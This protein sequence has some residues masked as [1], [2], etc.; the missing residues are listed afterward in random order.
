MAEEA[1]SEIDRNAVQNAMDA[2]TTNEPILAHLDEW[3]KSLI[4]NGLYEYGVRENNS[5]EP[6]RVI[7]KHKYPELEPVAAYAISH[8]NL[9]L[10]LTWNHA[11]AIYMNWRH[12]YLSLRKQYRD[13]KEAL[14]ILRAIDSVFTESL[15]GGSL[16]G[17]HQSYVWHLT[18]GKKEIGLSYKGEEGK[19]K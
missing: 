12:Q 10:N 1:R 7:I 19:K 6:E 11:V 4:M 16:E 5:G 13:K 2:G 17:S 15:Y 8:I 18:G 9:I 14:N 3:R